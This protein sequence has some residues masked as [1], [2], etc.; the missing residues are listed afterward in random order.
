MPFDRIRLEKTSQCRFVIILSKEDITKE[1]SE[2]RVPEKEI[3]RIFARAESAARAAESARN[4]SRLQERFGKTNVTAFRTHRSDEKCPCGP[5]GSR[6]WIGEAR[7]TPRGTS[8]SLSRRVSHSSAVSIALQMP[9]Q[10]CSFCIPYT[11]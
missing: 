3:E 6:A 2:M 1:S 4:S 5:A 11:G 10:P 8:S 7:I 9:P